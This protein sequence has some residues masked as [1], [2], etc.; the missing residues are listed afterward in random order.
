MIDEPNLSL[1]S[2]DEKLRMLK[3]LEV[4][5]VVGDI[6]L[7][8]IKIFAKNGERANQISWGLLHF[9]IKHDV[10]IHLR[11]LENYGFQSDKIKYEKAL[12]DCIT[13][14]IALSQCHLECR[15]MLFKK[16]YPSLLRNRR[17]VGDCIAKSFGK[18]L[19]EKETIGIMPLLDFCIKHFDSFMHH[20]HENKTVEDEKLKMTEYRRSLHIMTYFQNADYR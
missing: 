17:F 5:D 9:S 19:G 6:C 15:N 16:L 12:S 4:L 13:S 18:K 7:L 3:L 20:I 11:L 10:Q 2:R 8:K 1:K 14:A